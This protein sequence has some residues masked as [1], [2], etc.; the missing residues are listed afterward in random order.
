M[1]K[2]FNHQEQVE[3]VPFVYKHIRIHTACNSAC[4]FYLHTIIIIIE[5]FGKGKLNQCKQ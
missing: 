1:F 4:N 5:I 2:K 3:N